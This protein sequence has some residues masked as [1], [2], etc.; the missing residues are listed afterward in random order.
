[1]IRERLLHK[2][3]DR[4]AAVT[5]DRS[6]CLGMRLDGFACATCVDV[7]P[8]G[9]ITTG[10]DI[11]L[12]ADTC[13]QCMLCVSECP[14]GCFNGSKPDFYALASKLMRL[15]RSLSSPV[16]GCSGMPDRKA[17]IKGPCFGYLSYEHL[18]FLAFFVKDG[19]QVD[20][21]G[22]VDCGNGFVKERIKERLDRIASYAF[23]GV[24]KRIILVLHEDELDYQ[25]I[26]Y[27]RRGFFTVL[28][29]ATL[30]RTADLLDRQDKDVFSSA[31][32]EKK[33]PFRRELLNKV[34]SSLSDKER[35]ALTTNFYYTVGADNNCDDCFSCVG[36]CPTG[37]LKV[38]PGEA[39]PRLA[40]SSALCSGCGLCSGFCINGS[41]RV[42]KGFWE[43]DPF[44]FSAVRR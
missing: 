31:Y 20:L 4:D 37:A 41:L 19:F 44:S 39:S 22:C 25:D 29:N 16:L 10:D 28:K 35:K 40:F 2:A 3:L 11:V 33:L 34:L 14:S 43:D 18:I 30:S 38:G 5:V 9:A 1:M 6:R 42:E 27:D 13:T 36:I 26:T 23:P 8:A 7:C 15:G 24:A 21:A 17:H 32:S 12:D